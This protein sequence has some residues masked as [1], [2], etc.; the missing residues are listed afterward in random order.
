MATTLLPASWQIPDTI[1]KRLG[2]DV[3]R[4]RVMQQDDHLLL[5][6]HAPPKPEDD[7][8][9]GRFFWRQPDGQW[10]SKDLG[11]GA[12]A[13]MR[14]V[15]EY[16]DLIAR[17]DNRQETAST[18]DEYYGILSALAPIHRCAR[19][20]HLVL[21]EARKLCPDDRDLI[22]L[23]DRAYA[24]DRNAELLYEETKNALDFAVAK[25]M[26]EQAESS[27]YMMVTGHRLNMLVAFFF[28]IATLTAIFGVNLEHG[29]ERHNVPYPFAVTLGVGLLLGL[30]LT[31]LVRQRRRR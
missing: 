25:R 27:R 11:A 20:L 5:V 23:R 12:Q 2:H 29:Y 17:L 22:N 4:Q 13:L 24:V 15:E 31:A 14:H 8:R 10:L 30:L 26:E 6:L 16:E 28:P 7:H 19:H 1:R 3:G 9:L 21:Q 18:A